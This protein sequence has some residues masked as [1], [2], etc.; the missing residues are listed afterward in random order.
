[1]NAIKCM[2]KSMFLIGLGVG[3][4]IAYQKYSKPLSR[5]IEKLI[6]KTVKNV[7]DELEEMM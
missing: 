6:D 2:A 7:N 3:A 4:T 1:M 5:E